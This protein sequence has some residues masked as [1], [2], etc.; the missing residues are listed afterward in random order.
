MA[1]DLPHSVMS[2]TY[3]RL[4]FSQ[5]AHFL[6]AESS[7]TYLMLAGRSVDLV[8]DSEKS[9]P[10]L[11]NFEA[12][13]SRQFKRFSIPVTAQWLCKSIRPAVLPAP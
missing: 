13:G 7:D 3:A 1:L 9:P 4:Y 5:P 2:V 8:E 10:G 6:S 12:C 11:S